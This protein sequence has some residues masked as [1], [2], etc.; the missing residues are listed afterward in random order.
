MHLSARWRASAAAVLATVTAGIGAVAA[1]P[2]PA[3]AAAACQVSY[4]ADQWTG[5]F[6]GYVKLT[7]GDTAIHGWTVGWTWPGDQKI[8]N[9]W[10]ASVTQSGTAVTA[11]NAAYN[12]DLAPGASLEFGMQG[13]WAGNNTAPTAFTV[14]GAPCGATP[15][16]V[17]SSASPSP[18]RSSSPSPSV[19]P[20]RSTSPSPSASPRPSASPSASPSPSGPPPA[21]CTGALWC[22]GFED[23]TGTV[24]SGAWTLAYPDCQGTGSAVVDT[25]VARSGS[26]SVR[27]DGTAG[28]CNH[29][30]LKSTRDFS[31]LGGV[32]YGRFYVRHT[33]ALPSAHVTF[34]AMRDAADGNRD[35]RVGG[36]NAALQWNR[37]SDDA[38]LPEQSPTGVAL[39]RPLPVDRWVCVE[40][41]VDG[42]AG[43]VQTWTDGSE[44]AGLRVDGVPT[45][46]VDRQWLARANWHPNLT[47]LRLGW[48][49]YGEGA[50]RLWFDDIAWGSARIGC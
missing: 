1:A 41:R 23:Q 44:V 28:Y 33:T 35:L 17:P 49:S 43:Q 15:S 3:G 6:V 31:A 42:P 40:I 10:N 36:Q 20:S 2:P 19:S 48:E 46:D 29:V 22:D 12:G 16:P 32:W 9:A 25:T 38:T 21:G 5:G 18:S 30:F 50:D 4:R 11:V 13:T 27:V 34:L 24:P 7:A 45:A 47:D 26:R 8:T 37:Q 39:S 14:N